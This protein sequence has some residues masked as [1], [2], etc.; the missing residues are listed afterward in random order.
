M[1]HEQTISN[2]MNVKLGKSVELPFK[3]EIYVPK[4]GNKKKT[5]RVLGICDCCTFEI[6]YFFGSKSRTFVFFLFIFLLYIF[7][8][9]HRDHRITAD[10]DDI[11]H[12]CINQLSLILLETSLF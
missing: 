10:R 7:L 3:I 1:L 4:I 9:R 12:H 8:K 5:N 6:K 2:V 11:S